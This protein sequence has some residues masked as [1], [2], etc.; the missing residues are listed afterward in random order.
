MRITALQ[1]GT[2]QVKE[3]FLHPAPGLRGRLDLLLPGPFAPPMP[4]L[5]WLIEHDG[6]RIL[7]DTGETAAVRDLPFARYH[8]TEGDELPAAL[9]GAGVTAADLDTVILTHLHSDH[10]D[11]TVHVAGPVLVGDEEWRTSTGATGRLR[12]RITRAPLPTGV[13]FR[14]I[15][16]DEGPFGTFAAHRR[17]T[18]DGRVLAVST[19]GHTAGHLSVL[20]IDDEGRHVLLAGDTTDSLEQL[21]ARRPDPVAPKPVV[22]VETIERILVHGR[23]HPTIYLPAHDPEGPARLAAG[24]TLPGA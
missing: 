16:L 23:E 1:T 6:H 19:P 2:A 12:Q 14:P 21:L 17:L 5:Q 13:D 4:I 9:A 11:G 10:A 8:V 7:V 3:A 20:A 18:A 15:A 24:T 22:Q